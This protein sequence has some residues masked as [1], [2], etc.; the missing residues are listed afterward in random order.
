MTQYN[1]ERNNHTGMVES[2]SKTKDKETVKALIHIPPRE[3]VVHQLSEGW[4]LD[5]TID[6][7]ILMLKLARK[8]DRRHDKWTIRR[9]LRKRTKLRKM[10]INLRWALIK[11]EDSNDRNIDILEKEEA[12]KAIE[13]LPEHKPSISNS[14]KK[15]N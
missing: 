2:I 4:N 12:L 14:N 1:E 9:E 11:Q 6:Y 10:Q 3:P 7:T 8:I 13:T 5:D 15:D